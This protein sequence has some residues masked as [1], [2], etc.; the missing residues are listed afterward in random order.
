MFALEGRRPRR[1]GGSDSSTKEARRNVGPRVKE[2]SPKVSRSCPRWLERRLEWSV[3]ASW[4]GLVFPAVYRLYRAVAARAAGIP[5]A[6]DNQPNKRGDRRPHR[7]PH[8]RPR[9]L[10][11]C[12]DSGVRVEA[13]RVRPRTDCRR[14]SFD[15]HQSRRTPPFTGHYLLTRHRPI[16]LSPIILAHPP[17]LSVSP[18]LA[19]SP[20]ATHSH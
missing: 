8:R 5:T 7:R 20:S 4:E 17:R 14:G 11:E 15:S 6:A 9:L 2:E 3:G 10:L 12:G 13:P 16:A 18:S 1:E 19:R